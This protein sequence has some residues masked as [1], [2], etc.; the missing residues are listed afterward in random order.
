MDQVRHWPVIWKRYQLVPELEVNF[1]TTKLRE[2]FTLGEDTI[3]PP[4]TGPL[5]VP[6]YDE[7]LSYSSPEPP[8]ISNVIRQLPEEG[9]S[10]EVLELLNTG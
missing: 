10:A 3:P 9:L 1:I 7:P 2:F 4:P 5:P 8:R 6:N